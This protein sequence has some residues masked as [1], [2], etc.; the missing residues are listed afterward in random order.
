MQDLLGNVFVMFFFS[1][2]YYHGLLLSAPMVFF[3]LLRLYHGL[4]S[5]ASK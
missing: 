2:R 4:M 1:L 5:P 3:Y